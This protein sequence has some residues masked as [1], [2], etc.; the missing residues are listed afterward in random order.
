MKL[1]DIPT[2]SQITIGEDTVTFD[3]LDGMYS[4][5]TVNGNPKIVVHLSRM[6]PLKKVGDHYEI[7]REL[8]P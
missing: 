3:H 1:K 7:D 2:G 5:C 4:Y 8:K 6:T